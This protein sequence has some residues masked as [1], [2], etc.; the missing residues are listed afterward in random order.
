M[1]GSG[2]S[3]KKRRKYQYRI[4]IFKY[5]IQES[6][7]ENTHTH[8][9]THTNNLMIVRVHHGDLIKHENNFYWYKNICARLAHSVI[10]DL[11]MPPKKHT[12]VVY[13]GRFALV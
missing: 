7:Q 8:T 5:I 10:K 1:L 6:K 12:L 3:N 9:H 13:E 4:F 11:R 2:P